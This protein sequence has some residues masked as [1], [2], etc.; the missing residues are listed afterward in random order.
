MCRPQNAGKVQLSRPQTAAKFQVGKPHKAYGWN[1]GNGRGAQ[2]ARRLSAA[3]D[4]SIID[5]SNTRLN[6]LKKKK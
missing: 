1:D 6:F 3:S 4:R 5:R 2:G